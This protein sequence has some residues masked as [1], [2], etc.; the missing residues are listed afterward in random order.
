MSL[1]DF[2]PQEYH[3][4][5][6]S[7][8]Y[9]PGGGVTLVPVQFGESSEPN[10]Y[11]QLAAPQQGGVSEAQVP[12]SLGE[13]SEPN[14]S[15]DELAAPQQASLEER[16]EPNST[17]QLAA[18]QQG[19]VSEIQLP[20]SLGE[21]SEPNSTDELAAPQQASLA[22]WGLD[23]LV[24]QK[25][26]VLCLFCFKTLFAR[27]AFNRHFDDKHSTP[28]QCDMCDLMVVGERKLKAHVKRDH[29]DTTAHSF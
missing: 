18:P 5:R 6:V 12:A 23:V 15:T 11:D 2:T 20:A 7:S 13:P 27:K 10:S 21:P 26:K 19:G 29:S 9:S 8:Y 22:M 4:S 3:L 25:R 28:R 16:S 14:S 1:N 17:E 24:D